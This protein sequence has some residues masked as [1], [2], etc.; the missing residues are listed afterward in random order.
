MRGMRR[1][2]YLLFKQQDGEIE[3]F[4]RFELQT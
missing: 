4:D 1:R 2:R 3:R